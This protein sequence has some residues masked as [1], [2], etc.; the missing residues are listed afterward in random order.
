MKPAKWKLQTLLAEGHP[1]EEILKAAKR[2][3]ADLVV[4]G[5]RGLTG[6]EKILLGSVSAKVTRHAA[7]SVLV[8]GT[9]GA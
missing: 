4:M 7:C 9:K 2:L 5:S 6:M 8:V 1:A 3:R